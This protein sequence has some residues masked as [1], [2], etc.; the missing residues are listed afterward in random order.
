MPPT[1]SRYAAKNE[2]SAYR[3]H[4]LPTLTEAR[5]ILAEEPRK[6]DENRFFSADFAYP[7][8][9]TTGLGLRPHIRI[10][11]TLSPPT[12]PTILRTISSLIG[13]AQRQSA[14]VAGFPLRRSCR[15][16]RRHAQRACVA[17][18]RA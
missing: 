3:G 7:S 11:M 9:F 8:L 13:M 2:H 1:K 14:E 12:L 17:R 6:G 5:F 16:R 4:I 15:D 10:E 18:A